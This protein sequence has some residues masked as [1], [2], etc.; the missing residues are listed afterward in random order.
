MVLPV[1]LHTQTWRQQ[2]HRDFEAANPGYARHITV[3][4]P[5]CRACGVG[6]LHDYGDVKQ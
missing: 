5:A 4:G 2:A 3:L 6:R 1:H